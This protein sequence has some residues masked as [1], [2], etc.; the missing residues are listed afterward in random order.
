MARLLRNAGYGVEHGEDLAAG[1]A[2]FRRQPFDLIVSDVGLP[3]GSG[4]ELL[5]QLREIQPD[6]TGVCLSGYG[7]EGDV[8]A[9]RA[10]GFSEHLIKPVDLQQLQ[11][12]IRRVLAARA[13]GARRG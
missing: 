13:Q 11:A 5:R 8:A 9:S 12:A 10:A 3:D 1:L 6:F 7:M 2:L 4:L